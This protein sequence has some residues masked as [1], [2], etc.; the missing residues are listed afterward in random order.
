MPISEYVND[1]W[2]RDRSPGLD[3]GTMTTCMR[4]YLAHQS[5]F[6]AFTKAP[7][8]LGIWLHSPHPSREVSLQDA[9]QDLDALLSSSA[10]PSPLRAEAADW[11]YPTAADQGGRAISAASAERLLTRSSRLI[12]TRSR[13]TSNTEVPNSLPRN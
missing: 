8:T 1:W 10:A 11:T 9:W 7:R 4:L 12:G 13:P 6:Y 2:I 5:D 3:L